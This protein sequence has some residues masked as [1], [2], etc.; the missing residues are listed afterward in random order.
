MGY[1]RVMHYKWIVLSDFSHD[2]KD[3]ARMRL[4]NKSSMGQSFFVLDGDKWA[5]RL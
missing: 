5:L 3:F 1:L 2:F 4:E